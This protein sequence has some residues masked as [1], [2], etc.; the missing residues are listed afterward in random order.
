VTFPD[1]ITDSS[2]RDTVHVTSDTS[3]DAPTLSNE[4]F[5]V[6]TWNKANGSPIG[7]GKTVKSVTGIVTWFF[8]FHIA[9]RSPADIEQ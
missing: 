1:S 8:S 2:G 5:D 3:Q 4:L 9:P 6:A 7:A